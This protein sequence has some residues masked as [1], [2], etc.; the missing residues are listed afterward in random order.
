MALLHARVALLLALLLGRA[1]SAG[2]RMFGRKQGA[3]R[4]LADAANMQGNYRT[5][6][7]LAQTLHGAQRS[8]VPDS[9]GGAARH[10]EARG[11]R[12]DAAVH[13]RLGRIGVVLADNRPP[14]PMSGKGSGQYWSMAYELARR[15][16][17]VV[18]HCAMT[19][20]P[21]YRRC[22]LVCSPFIFV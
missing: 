7:E 5:R 3:A 9:D 16:G 8:A 10:G 22:A 15:W 11:A 13:G 17:G 14:E 19:V 1:S 21:V 4:P 18:C 20:A 2:P 12:A 6:G